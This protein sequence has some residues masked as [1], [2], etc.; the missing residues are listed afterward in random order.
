MHRINSE[1]NLH[2]S[3]GPRT[4]PA[5]GSDL[6]GCFQTRLGLCQAGGPRGRPLTAN[7]TDTVTDTLAATFTVTLA[8]IFA[9]TL[10]ATFTAAFTA[11]RAATVLQMAQTLRR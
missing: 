7:F 6:E 9:A 1:G 10:V 5:V 3:I 2:S 8:A 11:T 4:C